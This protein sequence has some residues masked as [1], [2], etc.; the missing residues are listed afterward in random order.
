MAAIR[1]F[2]NYFITLENDLVNI[3]RYIELAEDNFSTYSIELEKLLFSACSDFEVVAKELA[4]LMTDSK[5]NNIE[6]IHEFL[7]SHLHE[8]FSLE[9]GIDRYGIKLKPFEDWSKKEEYTLLPWWTS[10]NKVKHQRTEHYSKANL[11]NALNSLSAL[12]IINFHYY[13]VLISQ[14]DGKYSPNLIKMETITKILRP[15]TQLLEVNDRYYYE[16]PYLWNY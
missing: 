4:L 7:S 1:H 6:K 14:E 5:P 9:V 15:K 16:T 11:N 2:W 10:Y 13:Q 3:S 8:I 12:L